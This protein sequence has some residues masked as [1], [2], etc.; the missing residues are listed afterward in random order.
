MRASRIGKLQLDIVSINLKKENIFRQ[1]GKKAYE[2]H[3]RKNE[4]E[5]AKL[6]S[7]FNQVDKLTQQIKA[8]KAQIARLKK[9]KK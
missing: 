9:G 3:S 8:K 4:I 6:A 7:F 1:V 5:P 2:I